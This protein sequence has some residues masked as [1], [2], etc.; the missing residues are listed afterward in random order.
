MPVVQISIARGRDAAHKRALLQAV[1]DALVSAFKV[2]EHDRVQRI[3][4]FEPDDFEVPDEKRLNYT[5]I[6]I[7]VF[8]GR[9]PEAKKKLF[10]EIV[11]RLEPLGIPSANVL[12]ILH[13]PPLTDWGIHGGRPA[14]EVDLG[15]DLKV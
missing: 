13:E 2:P 8:P 12:I 5:L 14:N 4:E 7:T 6:E 15:F 1:H 9:S 3:V 11:S 10:A